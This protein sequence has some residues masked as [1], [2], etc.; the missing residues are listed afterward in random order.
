MNVQLQD[1]LVNQN[2]PIYFSVNNKIKTLSLS[3]PPD[4][5]IPLLKVKIGAELHQNAH[6]A[7]RDPG[8]HNIP[9]NHNVVHKN[10]LNL[11]KFKHKR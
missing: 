6:R 5:I 7:Q 2:L 8:I 3:T 9:P 11:A 4:N 10:V 1:F